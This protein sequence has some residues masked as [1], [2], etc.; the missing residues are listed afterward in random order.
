MSATSMSRETLGF[1]CID[2]VAK[3][4]EKQAPVNEGLAILY[5]SNELRRHFHSNF[6]YYQ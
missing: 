5:K 1:Y 2:Y 3:V 6:F 4:D